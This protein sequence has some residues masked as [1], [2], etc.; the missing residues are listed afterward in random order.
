VLHVKWI[1]IQ[2][3]SAVNNQPEVMKVIFHRSMQPQSEQQDKKVNAPN[4]CLTFSESA[5]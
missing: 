2:K 3:I 1:P 4:T 5:F